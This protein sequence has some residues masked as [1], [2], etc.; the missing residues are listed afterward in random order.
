MSNICLDG[1]LSDEDKKYARLSDLD[2]LDIDPADYENMPF[3]D[4]PEYIAIP[5]LEQAWTHTDDRSNFNL[6]PNSNMDFNYKTP[7]NTKMDNTRIHDVK[8]LINYTKKQMMAGKKGEVLKKIIQQKSLP[9]IIKSALKHLIKLSEEQGLLGDV[10][11]D[12]TI[13]KN[14]DKG[15]EFVRKRAKTAKYV[16]AMDKC[17]GCIFNH[18]NRCENYK[19]HIAKDIVYDEELFN[20]YSKHLSNTAGKDIKICSRKELQQAFV[21]EITKETK[22]AEF[23]PKISE[24]EDEKTLKEKEDEYRNHMESL[25]KELSNVMGSK[26][27]KDVG[28]MLSKGYSGKIIKD[29]IDKKYSAKEFRENKE[30]ISNLLLKQGSLGHVYLDAFLL[31][32]NICK[33]KKAKD[34]LEKQARDIKYIVSRCSH[35]TCRCKNLNKKIVSKLT[36]IPKEVWDAKFNKY[37]SDIKEKI[38]SIYNKNPQKGLRLAFLQEDISKV[39]FKAPK[40]I[41]NYNL[42]EAIDINEYKV[43]EYKGINFTP[44][45]ITAALDKG[46][47]LSSIM[48]IGKKL[49]VKEQEIIDNIKKAFDEN[50][51]SVNKYQIDVAIDI[52]EKINIVMTGKDISNDLEKPLSDIHKISYDSS[53]APSD[54]L[55]ND[56]QLTE[57]SLDT[58]SISTNYDDDGVEISG[59]GQLTID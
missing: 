9:K 58:S 21:K 48:Y 49:G 47:T 16:L 55:V 44:K 32:I 43:K 50:V 5:K 41:E 38:A 52:P 27:A 14:C 2:W 22:V 23:K 39:S 31:P 12:P 45:K 1:F 11:I 28:I 20:F 53:E 33:D 54:T 40:N 10:Y 19:K 51:T 8:E 34:Y 42:K 56:L 18:N 15:A 4:T 25:K 7:D 59:L 3:D 35:S 17:T 46:F 6:V 29:H 57:S 37:S 36:D 24:T 26:V 13:F 30:I